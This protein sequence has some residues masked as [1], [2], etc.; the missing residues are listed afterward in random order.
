MRRLPSPANDRSGDEV[1]L[2]RLTTDCFGTGSERKLNLLRELSRSRDSKRMFSSAQK[3]E[4][5][6]ERHTCAAMNPDQNNDALS[7]ACS[8]NPCFSV[9]E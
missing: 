7:R 1:R 5:S 2:P 6:A 4:L 9:D 8:E 3:Q